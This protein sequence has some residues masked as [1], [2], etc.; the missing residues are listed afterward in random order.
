[1]VTLDDMRGE[2]EPWNG[3]KLQVKR[4]A[5]ASPVCI[6]KLCCVCVYFIYIY[7]IIAVLLT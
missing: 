5:I 4:V 1:M 2:L 6:N 7:Y 3:K